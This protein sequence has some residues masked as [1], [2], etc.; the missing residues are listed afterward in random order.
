MPRSR[1]TLI[2]ALVTLCAGGGLAALPSAFVSSASA[3]SV[4]YNLQ[5]GWI[6]GYEP[7]AGGTRE[8]QNGTWDV[9]AMNMSTGAF[10]G[11]AVVSD[12][13]FA[14]Q[15]TESG[16]VATFTLTEGSYV[17]YDTLDLSVLGDG[18][19]GGDGS[20]ANGAEGPP[21]GYF[22]AELTSPTGTTTTTSSSSSSSTTTS[23]TTTSTSSTTAQ[24]TS[25]GASLD[26]TATGVQ[27]DFYVASANDICTATVGDS[28]GNGSTPTGQ[29]SFSGDRTGA[30]SLQATPSSPGVANCS[31]TVTGSE[32]NFLN[33]TAAYAGDATHAASTGSTQFLTAA[34][35]NGVFNPTIETFNP[36]TLTFTED[37]PVSGSTLTGQA[38]LTGD[39]TAADDGQSCPAPESSSDAAA[40]T[41]RRVARA[42]PTISVSHTIR[43]ARKGRVAFALKFNVA[44]LRKLF[45]GTHTLTLALTVTITPPHGLR[46]TFLVLDHLTLR[47]PAHGRLTITRV[48]PDLGSGSHG[49]AA[50]ERPAAEPRAT[51]GETDLSFSGTLPN[52]CGTLKLTVTIPPP[53]DANRL[54][55]TT[56]TVTGHVSYTK[57]GD[58]DLSSHP[59]AF[60]PSVTIPGASSVMVTVGSGAQ[61][62]QV[63]MISGKVS[64]SYGDNLTYAVN[65][66]GGALV[67]TL[68]TTNVTCPAFGIGS[69]PMTTT[70][71]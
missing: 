35:G 70:G 37:N 18:N 9:T 2:I 40:M 29:V 39:G 44:E 51:G 41:A 4:T 61:V 26:P 32:T 25:T 6:T 8:P 31:I 43:R 57:C 10:S 36:Q 3:G 71:S 47:A 14:L 53:T 21:T 65:S 55:D 48:G 28:T 12:T 11:T 52:G 34:P 68:A 23:S 42:T 33:I 22:W 67:G 58:L 63:A 27:C 46:H 64:N 13:N 62:A 49:A 66:G 1:C 56:A 7:S 59:L 69:V 54:A 17:A 50:R 24:T 30:C 20:F 19:V 45:P 16:S 38:T 5:G 15:G 60:D